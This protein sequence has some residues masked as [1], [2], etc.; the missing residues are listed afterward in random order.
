MRGRLIQQF[1][2]VIHRLDPAATAAVVGGGYSAAF[3][4]PIRVR[5]GTQL[6]AASRRELAP[7]RL[8]CQIDRTNFNG[9]SLLRSGYQPEHQLQIALHW[10]ALEAG[11]LI[12]AGG[13]P[14]LLPGDRVA[15]IETIAGA[16]E[17]TFPNPPGLWVRS[18]ERA[19]HGLAAFGV[20]RT[21]LLILHCEV[22]R[23]EGAG[24]T[25]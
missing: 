6:G 8:R 11:G 22:G 12:D 19:G 14:L 18:C 5:D 1:V 7:I 3:R 15:A 9:A 21:N 10:P 2:A 24:G 20:P 17:A 4:E 16:T 13:N 23:A 25:P